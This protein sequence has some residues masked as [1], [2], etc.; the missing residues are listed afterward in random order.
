MIFIT[1]LDQA[2]S[3]VGENISGN[4]LAGLLVLPTGARREW[5]VLF[6]ADQLKVR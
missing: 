5:R 6:F 4:N 2:G 3:F 1:K